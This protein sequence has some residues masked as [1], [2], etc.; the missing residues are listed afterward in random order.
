MLTISFS[1]TN[2][3]TGPASL[4]LSS[5]PDGL[6]C[7]LSRTTVSIS[8]TATLTCNGNSPGTYVV[9]ITG[10]S[11]SV[12]R[13][14]TTMVTVTSTTIFGLNPTIFYGILGGIVTLIVVGAGVA[15]IKR[16]KRPS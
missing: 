1:G 4:S 12:T 15:L 14:T 7:V 13:T 5:S 6:S 8:Q 3:F 16:K 10:T 2:G 9:T 11:G